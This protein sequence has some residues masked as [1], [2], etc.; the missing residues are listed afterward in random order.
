MAAAAAIRERKAQINS[1]L[2]RTC[3]LLADKATLSCQLE[4]FSCTLQEGPQRYLNQ[5]KPLS[6]EGFE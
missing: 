4:K 2:D 3:I 1:T 5:M 6:W